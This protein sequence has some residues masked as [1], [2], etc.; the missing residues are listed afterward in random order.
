MNKIIYVVLAFAVL[1]TPTSCGDITDTNIDPTRLDDV[2]LSL[3]APIVL[4]GHYR[5]I[6]SNPGRVAGIIMQQYDGFDAQQ[7]QYSTYVLGADAMNNYWRTGLYAGPLKD[8]QVMIDKAIAEGNPFYEGLGK[9]IFA[10]AIADAASYFGDI[11]FSEALLGT[12]A[13]QPAYD[14]QESVYDAALNLFDEAIGALEKDNGDH[15]GGDLVFAGD[16]AGWIRTARG[17]KARYLMQLQKRRDVASEVLSLIDQ[18]LTGVADEARFTFSTAQTANW[19]L[20][21][22]GRERT[23]TLVINNNFA[24][25]MEANS[26]PR[27]PYYMKFDGTVWQYWVLGDQELVWAIDDAS[28]PL[29]SYSELMFLKAEALLRTSAATA[30]VEAAL[31]DAIQASMDLIGIPAEDAMPYVD[32]NSTLSGDF[33]QDLEKIMTEAYVAYYGH[34]FSQTW[35]NYRRTGHPVLTPNPLGTNGFNPS[36]I[37]PRRYLYVDSEYQTNTDNVEAA[38]ARQNGALLDVD[39]WAFE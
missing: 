33:D 7:V 36:G 17:L 24:D 12:E 3:M 1:L 21:K 20:A 31:A 38:A 9:L 29:I 27:Q 32:A 30:D 35:A 4:S 23:N 13:L 22:F 39:V 8:A 14:S 5:N 16:A 34:N 2:N 11:P 26:D 37:V 18:S 6:G 15:V 28:V 19:T 10:T 25:L